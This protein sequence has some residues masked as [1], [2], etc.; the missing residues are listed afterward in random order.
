MFWLRVHACNS[1]PHS[2]ISVQYAF[3]C[4]DLGWFCLNQC[5][6]V[7]RNQ[8]RRVPMEKL[9]GILF[10]FLLPVQGFSGNQEY[11]AL[12]LRFLMVNLYSRLQKSQ[13]PSI[14]LIGGVWVLWEKVDSITFCPSTSLLVNWSKGNVIHFLKATRK[15]IKKWLKME[16]CCSVEKG[17]LWKIKSN[18]EIR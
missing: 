6:G 18:V 9:W 11:E 7:T 8:P 17:N 1:Y 12:V 2:Q 5:N 14:A 13:F 16:T 10:V 3:H 15:H 4:H